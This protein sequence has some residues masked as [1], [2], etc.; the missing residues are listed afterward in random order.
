MCTLSRKKLHYYL[1]NVKT[2]RNPKLEFEQYC[3]S[4]QVAADILFNIQMM[5]GALEGMSVADLGCGTGM[6]S[7][8]AKLLGA[9]YQLRTWIRNRRGRCDGVSI[10]PR[11]I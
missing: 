3:T 4:A 11:D 9:R 6:L 2:F 7:I 1:E 8:G 10:K 5:D